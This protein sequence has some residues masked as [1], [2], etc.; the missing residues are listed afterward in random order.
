MLS[1]D[2]TDRQIKIVRGSL[3][4]S[5]IRVIQVETLTIPNGLVENGFIADVPM[6]ASELLEFFRTNDIKEK[7][8][9]VEIG[10]G[11]ILHKELILPKPKNLKNS[12]V[13]ETMI[14]S[15][16]NLSTDYNISFN[17]AEELEDENKNPMIRVLATAVPQRL[18]DG[19]TRLFSHLGLT[20]KSLYVSS[21]CINRLVENNPKMIATMPMMMVQVEYDFISINLYDEGRVVFSRRVSIDAEEINGDA[22]ALVQSVYDNVFRM[23]QFLNSRQNSK[24]LKEI[25]FYGKIPDF[26]LLTNAMSSFNTTNHVLSAPNNVV[27]FTEYDFAEYANAVSAFFKSKH[28]YDRIDLLKASAAKE[29]KPTSFYGLVLAGSLIG[30]AAVV[31]GAYFLFNMMNHDLISQKEVIEAE[32]N[33]PEIQGRVATLNAKIDRLNGISLYSDNI[34][35]AKYLFDFQ[36]TIVSEIEDKLLEVMPEGVEL[37]GNLTVNGYSVAA[38]FIADADNKPSEYVQALVDQGYFENIS[39]SGYEGKAPVQEE[40]DN[41]NNANRNNNNA[42]EDI[43]YTFSISMLLKGGN[44]YEVK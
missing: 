28:E 26:I 44:A 34:T 39:Y 1:L 20:L 29:K 42:D 6:L 25:T 2:F 7:E 33:S 24:P 19:Y 38:S 22:D 40:D 13:I 27:S 30:A 16:M 36:P 37:T 31:A 14:Q 43:T 32:I 8:I 35:I 23:I 15:N 18:V 12:F 10:S 21:S 11:L 5:K 9:I 3:A 4:G 41:N 17:I